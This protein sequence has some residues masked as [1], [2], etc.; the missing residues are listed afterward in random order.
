M[1]D[2]VEISIDILILKQQHRAQVRLD[3][4]FHTLVTEIKREF[5]EDIVAQYPTPQQ[6]ERAM[7]QPHFVWIKDAV[8]ALDDRETV[9][10]L[11]G[12]RRLVFGSI[13][14]APRRRRFPITREKLASLRSRRVDTALGLALVDE[15][16]GLRYDLNWMP[17][18]VGREGVIQYGDLR[19]RGIEDGSHPDVRYISRDH[20]AILEREGNYYVMPLRSDNPVYLINLNERLAPEQAYTLQKGDRLKLGDTNLILRFDKSI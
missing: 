13:D 6:G 16:S 17:I 19:Q 11:G 20:L 14:V 15:R 10:S 5:Y 18:I 8:D 9:Q 2:Y 3:T 7:Q 4:T 1:G 12:N